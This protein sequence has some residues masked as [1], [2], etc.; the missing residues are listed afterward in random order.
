ME[1]SPD[2][3]ISR[4][5]LNFAVATLFLKPGRGGQNAEKNSRPWPT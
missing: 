2:V 4:G 1:R 3:N 5:Y